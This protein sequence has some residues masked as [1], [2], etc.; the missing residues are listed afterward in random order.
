MRTAIEWDLGSQVLF[1]LAALTAIVFMPVEFKAAAAALMLLRYAA[2]LY[3]IRSIA[4]R[5]G[6]KDVALRF[7][8]FDLFNPL[9]LAAVRLS[10]VRKVPEAWR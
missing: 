2:A 7:F 3:R 1:L 5:V 4:R 9:L 8:I 6:E 10:L